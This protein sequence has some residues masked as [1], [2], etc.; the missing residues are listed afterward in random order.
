V[1]FLVIVA[2][3]VLAPHAGWWAGRGMYR[4]DVRVNAWERQHRTGVS[5]V[6]LEDAPMTARDVAADE[7]PPVSLSTKAWWVGPDGVVH[8]GLVAA[9]VGS[10]AGST[11][12]IWIDDHGAVT[13][14]PGR[15]SPLLDAIAAGLLAGSAV[16]AGFVGIRRIV[17]W[18]LDRRRL[19]SWQVEWMFVG[20]RWSNR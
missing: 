20:P 5:A 6:L 11:A 7:P 18:R 12:P 3:L 1:T 9:E 14:E 17:I 13:G 4:D 15:R 19:R 10:R 16:T 8:T 2:V